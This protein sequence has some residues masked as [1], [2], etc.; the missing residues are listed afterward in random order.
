MRARE[1]LNCKT[2]DPDPGGN[3]RYRILEIPLDSVHNGWVCVCMCVAPMVSNR[4]KG[5]EEGNVTCCGL[6]AVSFIITSY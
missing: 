2:I 4:G 5:M 1:F 3:G 6:K